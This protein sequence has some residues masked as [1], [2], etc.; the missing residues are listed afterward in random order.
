MKIQINKGVSGMNNCA[1][2]NFINHFKREIILE[3][4]DIYIRLI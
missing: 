3:I 1:F 2:S 4:K